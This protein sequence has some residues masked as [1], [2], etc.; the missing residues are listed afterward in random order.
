[1]VTKLLEEAG[2]VAGE[3]LGL[4]GIKP[5]GEYSSSTLGRELS[6]LLYDIFIIAEAYGV[7]LESMYPA[8]IDKYEKHLFKD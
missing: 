7:D 6:D 2:E 4:E 3:I 8:T 5:I 1:M